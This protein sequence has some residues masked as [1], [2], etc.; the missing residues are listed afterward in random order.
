M[1][2]N[3]TFQKREPFALESDEKTPL[4]MDKTMNEA[5]GKSKE[6]EKIKSLAANDHSL[7]L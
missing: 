4:S 6:V 3:N 5:I 7:P 1:N 2:I